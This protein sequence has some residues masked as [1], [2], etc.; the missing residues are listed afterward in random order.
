MCVVGF[1]GTELIVV[2]EGSF[3]LGDLFFI[4]EKRNIL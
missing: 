1:C 4:R 3:V 2:I